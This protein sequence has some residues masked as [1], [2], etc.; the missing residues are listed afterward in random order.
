MATGEESDWIPDNLNI[1]DFAAASAADFG[2]VQPQN[3]PLVFDKNLLKA[4]IEA[5]AKKKAQKKAENAGDPIDNLKKLVNELQPVRGDKFSTGK[6]AKF[7]KLQN[8]VAA[9]EADSAAA[10][11]LKALAASLKPLLIA[12]PG[13]AARRARMLAFFPASTTETSTNAPPDAPA[14]STEE[15]PQ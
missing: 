7:T 14:E 13:A 3:Q 1:A 15:A 6:T 10:D 4:S 8:E 11:D 2:V 9:I 5:D 12:E